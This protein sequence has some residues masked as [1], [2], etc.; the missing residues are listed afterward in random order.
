MSEKKKREKERME[1]RTCQ[2]HPLQGARR[3]GSGH[4]EYELTPDFTEG[5]T[6]LWQAQVLSLGTQTLHTHTHPLA[7]FR[8]SGEALS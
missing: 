3:A 5:T 6:E 1:F 7:R 4:L 8:S 2:P